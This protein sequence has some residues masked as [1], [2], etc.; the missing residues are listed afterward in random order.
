MLTEHYNALQKLENRA[1][2]FSQFTTY[3]DDPAGVETEP[4]RY[5]EITVADLTDVPRRA[6]ARSPSGSRSGWF[7][8]RRRADGRSE[9]NRSA[10]GRSEAGRI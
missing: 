8:G 4:E 9:A 10:T 7:P 1:D 3:F 6:S 5:E 2:T